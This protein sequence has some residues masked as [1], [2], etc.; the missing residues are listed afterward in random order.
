MFC[1]LNF[2]TID[3]GWL[4]QTNFVINE[5]NFDM[6]AY[7]DCKAKLCKKKHFVIV[8]RG[9]FNQLVLYYNKTDMLSNFKLD[10]NQLCCLPVNHKPSQWLLTGRWNLEEDL[11]IIARV[12]N[13]ASQ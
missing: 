6:N 10:D 3:I 5:V 8:T 12:F 11:L 4:L 7:N 9:L 13:S 1:H 2:I